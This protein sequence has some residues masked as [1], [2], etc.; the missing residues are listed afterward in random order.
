MG[1][2]NRLANMDDAFA[3]H[4]RITLRRIKKKNQ[5]VSDYCD[6]VDDFQ[7]ARA[8]PVFNSFDGFGAY[9]LHI[10]VIGFSQERA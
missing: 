5:P 2:K 4:T 3:G 6:V 1:T 8:G 9:V 10:S 7:I